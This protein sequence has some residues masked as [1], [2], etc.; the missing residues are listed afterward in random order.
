MRQAVS[1]F[2]LPRLARN[3]ARLFAR[4]RF[5]L[6]D[7]SAIRPQRPQVSKVTASGSGPQVGIDSIRFGARGF[8]MAID[9]FGIHWVD[10]KAGLKSK[11]R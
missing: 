10:G 6:L 4:E 7:E 9:R 8:A 1:W 3:Q 11:R 2:D 5:Q